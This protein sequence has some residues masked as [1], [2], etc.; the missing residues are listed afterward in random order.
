VNL[1]FLIA[2]ALVSATP[3]IYAALGELVIERAGIVNLGVEGTMLIGAVSGFIGAQL[4]GSAWL[5][6]VA[7]LVCGALFGTGFAV[8]TITARLDQIVAGLAFTILGSGLSSYIGAAYVGLAP[9]ASIHK[10]DPGVLGQIPF[11]GPVIFRQDALVLGAIILPVL[12]FCYLRFTRMGLVLTALGEKPDVLDSLGISVTALRYAYVAGGC[13]LMGLG[14]AYLSLA[15][16]PSWVERITAGRGWIAIALVIFGSWR[17]LWVFAG[18]V[19]F[20]LVEAVRFSI[21]LENFP[22]DPHFLNMLPYVVTLLVLAVA[23][24][25]RSRGRLGTPAALGVAYDRERR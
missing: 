6:V 16:I 7:A 13:A 25:S 5:G 3:L 11:L 22:I 20:G 14:G 4:T 12:L 1:T 18:A 19:L 2:A 10:L 24:R 15:Y 23:T 21:Q 9:R 8:L 17:P